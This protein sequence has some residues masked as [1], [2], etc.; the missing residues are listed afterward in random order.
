MGKRYA[1]AGQIA[2]S[3]FSRR[4][5]RSSVRLER[6]LTGGVTVALGVGYGHRLRN[7]WPFSPERRQ[8]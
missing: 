1:P 6:C 8:P 5:T 3:T 2:T 7:I 4:A